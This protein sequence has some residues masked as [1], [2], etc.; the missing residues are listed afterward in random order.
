MLGGVTLVVLGW[1]MVVW[2][3]VGYAP[4]R[5]DAWHWVAFHVHS[6]MSDGHGTPAEIARA[7]RAAGVGTVILADHGRPNPAAAA[8]RETFGGVEVIGGSEANLPEGHLIGFGARTA[9]SFWLP[10]FPPDA[11]ADLA[12]WGGAGVV[13]YPEDEVFRW[14]YWEPGFRPDM[15]EVLN[16]STV[17]RRLGGWE[18]ARLVAA[19]GISE[20]ALLDVLTPPV[21]ELARW[22]QLLAEGPV[23][24][25]YG[26]NAHGGVHLGGGVRLPVP[27]YEALFHL[28]AMGVSPSESDPAAALRRGD[29]FC[30]LRGAAEPARLRFDAASGATVYPA[31]SWNVPAGASLRL[32]VD[33]AGYAT[34]LVLRRDGRVIREM[35][36]DELILDGLTPGVYRAEIYLTGH[37]LL[38]PDVPWILTNPLRVTASTEATAEPGAAARLPEPAESAAPLRAGRAMET[39]SSE[40]PR[41]ADG[42][43]GAGGASPDRLRVDLSVF[44]IEKDDRTTAAFSSRDGVWTLDYDLAL[45]QEGGPNRWVAL[46]DR[47]SR[48]LSSFTGFYARVWSDSYRRY[49][50][51][52]RSG[53]RWYY[54]SF[55]CY[56]GRETVCYVPF[57]HF[58]RVLDGRQD[59]PLANIDAW[60]ISQSN[61][62]GPAGFS[63]RLEL[64]E[65]GFYR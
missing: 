42:P 41:A 59:I 14:R 51:E 29:C 54:A 20:F 57:A 31:G 12:E 58:Y 30:C 18:K 61:Y 8:F 60:F 5:H 36:G 24:A 43:P 28:W 6:T 21:A 15:L 47:Q 44:R 2:P 11:L 34:R 22:D 55:K 7:A 17:F 46:A 48:D 26:L 65:V 63:A 27:A 50:V 40:L 39:G 45:Y 37:P 56:P 10:P 13:A 3:Y 25:L 1:L 64:R 62:T 4:P 19:F 23:F 16:P 38:A 32:D 9:P 53:E 49:Y 35:S 33:V 52:I